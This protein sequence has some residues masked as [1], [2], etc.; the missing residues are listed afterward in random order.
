MPDAHHPH[1]GSLQYWPRKRSRH[2]VARIRSWT[3]SS[4]AKLLGFIAYKAGMTHAMAV[5]TRPNALTKGELV[6]LPVTI[7]DC[8]PLM[9][10][11][12][13]FYKH[14]KKVSSFF[15]AQPKKELSRRIQLAKKTQKFSFEN[16][17]DFDDLR[18]LVQTQP[19]FTGVAK[20]PQLLELALGGSKDEKLAFAKEKL[21]KEI[22]LNEVFEQ[23]NYVDVHGISKGKGFQGTVKR[24]G[25][26]IRQ[27]KAEKTKRGIGTLGSWTPE[28][29]QFSVPQSGKMGYHLRTEYNKQILKLGQ[30]GK[31]VT[32][33][34]GYQKYGLVKNNY[35]VI[36]GSVVGSQKRAV[37]LTPALRPPQK[38]GKEI[39]EVKTVV[40]VA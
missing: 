14:T 9:I 10:A 3:G 29:V 4:K 37:V 8:P 33:S 12:V 39:P 24:F 17:P 1:H 32:P 21:G 11:G 38:M 7:L 27:H 20:K 25:V 19:K 23:G 28:Y 34:S 15:A 5:E 26:P 2:L 6:S 18:L 22:M 35:L 31:E 13:A 36:K 30:D 16:L 40:G